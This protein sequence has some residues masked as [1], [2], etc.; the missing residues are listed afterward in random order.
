MVTMSIDG[1][2]GEDNG[3][4]QLFQTNV[5]PDAV[6]EIK[7][8][9]NNYQAEYGR[10]GG[11][12]VNVITKSGTRDFHGSAYW[13]KRH[14]MFNANSFFNNRSGLPKAKYRFNTKGAT[15]GGPV[16]IPRVFN[17]ARQKLFFFYNFDSNPSTSTPATP[18]RQTLP[19]AEERAGNFSQSLN[20]GGALIAV[21]DPLS[22]AN[23]PGNVIPAARINKNGL[24][25]LDTM[26]LPN[27]LNRALTAGAYNN[28]FLNVTPNERTQHL[29]RVDYRLTDRQSIYFRGTTFKTLNIRSSLTSFDGPR[30][31]FGVPSKTAVLGWTS[32]VSTTMVNEFTAG[33]KREHEET[34]IDDNKAFRKTYGFTSGQF[35]PEINYDDL[36]PAVSYSGGG[37]QNTPSYGNYQAGRF[38]QLEADI[39]YYLNDSFTITRNKHTF[40]FGIYAEKDRVT[41]GSGFGTT[42]PGS[43]SFNV[44]T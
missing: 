42:P 35:H 20:P 29:F 9:M 15:I 3:S 27:Q 18:S 6:Q 41:T 25:L 36:L 12:T 1:L 40:K 7:V 31:S 24:A 26:P 33:V 39:N 14:E 10:N 19:T 22:N 32:I 30:N 11:A 44:D 37:L 38:P 8:L 28:E 21:R 34:R 2:Q 16:M 43:F 23:F 4:S 5:A 13:F 17:T